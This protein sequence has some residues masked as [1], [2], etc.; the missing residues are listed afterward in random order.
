M[1]FV[2]AKGTAKLEIKNEKKIKLKT[3]QILL[4]MQM[5]G[6][7]LARDILHVSLY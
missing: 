5:I 2:P 6:K 4:V 7:K 1:H 3:L